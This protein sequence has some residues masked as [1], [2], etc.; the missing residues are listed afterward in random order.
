M[1]FDT[2]TKR[3]TQQRDENAIDYFSQEWIDEVVEVTNADEKM[4]RIGRKL[5]EKH[6]YIVLDCPDGTDRLGWFVWQQGVLV[7]AGFESHESPADFTDM[8]ALEDAA[9]ITTATYEYMKKINTKQVNAMKSLTSTELNIQGSRSQL[10]KQVK[11]LQHWQ[12]LFSEIPVTYG[13]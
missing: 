12:D 9:Y 3:K 5:N 2:S 8:P 6:C 7:D 11:Q 1:A 4:R 13:V 10:L